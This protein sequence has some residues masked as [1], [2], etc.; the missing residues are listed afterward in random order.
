MYKYETHLHTKEAS[1]CAG[2][3]GSE[4]VLAYK[5]AGYAG[6][7]ITDHF[8]YGNTCIDR[9]LPWNEWVEAFVKGYENAKK[10]GDEV[11]LQVF[12]GWESCYQGTEFLVY[13]LDKAWLLAHPEIKDATIEEQWELVNAGGGLIVHAHPF[14]DEPYI[15]EIRLFPQYVHAVEGI[16][17]THSSPLSYSHRNP[18]FNTQALEYAAKHDLPVTSGSDGHINAV[19]GGGVATKQPLKDIADYVKIIKERGEYELC[20]R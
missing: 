19:F 14:R 6:I 20:G 10:K 11:G 8:F 18:D 4:M 7:I 1:A 12:F 2:A 13:G 3:T 15:P 16:N 9:S 17:A 5:E